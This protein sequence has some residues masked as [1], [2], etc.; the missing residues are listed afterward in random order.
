[1]SAYTDTRENHGLGI[2]RLGRL[3]AGRQ[4][5]QAFSDDMNHKIARGRIDVSQEAIEY[6]VSRVVF[7][8]SHVDVTMI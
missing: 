1:M 8:L 7:L 5:S 4:S 3:E 2:N 6:R